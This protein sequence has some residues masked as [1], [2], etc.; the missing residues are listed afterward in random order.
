MAST[1]FCVS[2]FYNELAKPLAFA[3]LSDIHQTEAHA[4]QWR[5]LLPLEQCKDVP[6][7]VGP[8]YL[9]FCSALR[10]CFVEQL[11]WFGD[12]LKEHVPTLLLRWHETKQSYRYFFGRTG[13]LATSV[14]EETWM[15]IS[16]YAIPNM[17]LRD[18]LLYLLDKHWID[19][20]ERKLEIA[21][22]LLFPDLLKDV[23]LEMV[24]QYPNA[25]VTLLEDPGMRWS[26]LM[27]N[28]PIEA[29]ESIFSPFHAFQKWYKN[30]RYI[31]G[32]RLKRIFLQWYDQV[33]EDVVGLAWLHLHFGH[34]YRFFHE[35]E[36]HLEDLEK[37]RA[38]ICPSY[39]NTVERLLWSM[40]DD[41]IQSMNMEMK[42]G[43][44]GGCMKYASDMDRQ[45]VK[46]YDEQRRLKE[47]L[48]DYLVPRH[49]DHYPRYMKDADEAIESLQSHFSCLFETLEDGK[50]L[51]EWIPFELEEAVICFVNKSTEERLFRL[52]NLYCES[53]GSQGGAYS[54]FS[55]Q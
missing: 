29:I 50:L 36:D 38:M 48:C 30:G 16:P 20:D 42:Y 19:Y 43:G 2:R 22:R 12:T 27:H 49:R 7:D 40:R 5:R 47:T 4:K 37:V 6:R 8:H 14:I 39:V 52:R 33:R 32:K 1:F 21:L 3:Y 31:S 41:K 9:L 51:L 17:K 15:L 46:T 35:R 54:V 24:D 44:Y 18:D 55:F 53:R 13:T 45:F 34:C 26:Q 10:H 23:S 28:Y 11:R 25:S